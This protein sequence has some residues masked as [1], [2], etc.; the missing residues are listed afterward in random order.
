MDEYK[1]GQLVR[2]LAGRDKGEHYLVIEVL[3]PRYVLLA[4]GRSRP[5]SRLKK[6]NI[7]H[8]QRYNRRADILDL[9]NAQKLTDSQVVRLIKELAPRDDVSRQEV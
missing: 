9:L 3:G 5:L 4:N 8:L 2:S 1:P 6:K 7:A